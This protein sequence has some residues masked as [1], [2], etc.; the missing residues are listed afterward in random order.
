[1]KNSASRE[2]RN[3]RS[4][5]IQAQKYVKTDQ[6]TQFKTLYP[7]INDFNGVFKQ[8]ANWVVSID[9]F[10]VFFLPISYNGVY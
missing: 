9:L 5:W 4:W 8:D 10:W 1:M 2:N 7:F 6:I 3:S